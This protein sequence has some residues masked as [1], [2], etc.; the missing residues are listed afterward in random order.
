[1]QEIRDFG[2]VLDDEDIELLAV[3][4][5]NVCKLIYTPVVLKLRSL[6]DA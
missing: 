1:M 4:I 3:L 5:L 6:G 2:R